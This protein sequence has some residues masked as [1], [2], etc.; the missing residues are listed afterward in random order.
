MNSPNFLVTFFKNIF[1]RTSA[2][3]TPF[4]SESGCKDRQNFSTRKLFL[5]FF[6]NFFASYHNTLWQSVTYTLNVQN[7]KK[8]ILIIYK[9]RYSKSLRSA[10]KII[11][12]FKKIVALCINFQQNTCIY[13]IYAYICINNIWNCAYIVRQTL[14]LDWL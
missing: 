3:L 10:L 2:A 13:N 14:S 5:N 4:K 9:Y 7:P 8:N 6:T 1:R 12:Y 11:T